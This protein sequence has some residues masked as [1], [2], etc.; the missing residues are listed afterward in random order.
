MLST[1]ADDVILCKPGYQ[2]VN[3][4]ATVLLIFSR[5]CAS[6]IIS[7]YHSFCVYNSHFHNFICLTLTFDHYSMLH[8]PIHS[9]KF[10]RKT[11]F[12][13][14]GPFSGR[15][16]AKTNQT[17][18][19][20]LNPVIVSLSIQDSLKHTYLVTSSQY[21][22]FFCSCYVFQAE[23]R[24]FLHRKTCEIFRSSSTKRT[25]ATLSPGLVGT[26][27]FSCLART[28]AVIFPDIAKVLHI[29]ST[30]AGYEELAEQFEPIRNGDK[31]L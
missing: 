20:E 7:F 22:F 4:S 23:L 6:L 27:P 16:L 8:K 2:R 21:S 1:E 26:V 13:G 19:R 18:P 15:C 30:R 28:T 14:K 10:C 12:R 3:C 9:Q 29:W 31:L 24:L 11:P 17:Y 25:N 5:F